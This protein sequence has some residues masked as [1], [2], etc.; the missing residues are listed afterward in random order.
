MIFW[1]YILLFPQLIMVTQF[2]NEDCNHHCNA[3]GQLASVLAGYSP[4]KDS[5]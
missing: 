5:F 4:A 1:N 2:D 3:C